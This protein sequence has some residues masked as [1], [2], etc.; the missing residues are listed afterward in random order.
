MG[1]PGN[2]RNGIPVASGCRAAVEPR[3][4]QATSDRCELLKVRSFTQPHC[5][6]RGSNEKSATEDNVNS[7]KYQ[8]EL[9]ARDFSN[10][11]DEL[12]L[13]KGNY[14]RYICNGIRRQIS[15][16]CR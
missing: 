11:F 10:S 13:I 15:C 8:L 12:K 2:R 9:A 6:Q 4:R 7:R 14:Q 16:R 5:G 1:H 3:R